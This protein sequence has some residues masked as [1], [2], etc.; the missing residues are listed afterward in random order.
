MV[1]KAMG[2]YLAGVG[3]FQAWDAHHKSGNIMTIDEVCRVWFLYQFSCFCRR[4]IPSRSG[5]VI[6]R[7]KLGTLL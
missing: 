1:G 6:S 7:P 3:C 5:K 2:D 4:E